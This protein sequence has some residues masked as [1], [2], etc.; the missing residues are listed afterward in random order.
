MF[1]V[2]LNIL[3]LRYSSLI[4][5]WNYLYNYSFDL[6]L[7]I[8]VN[9]FIKLLILEFTDPFYIFQVFSVILWMFNHYQIYESLIIVTTIISLIVSTFET[10]ANLLSIQRM[11]KYSCPINVYRRNDNGEREILKID[12]TELVPATYS[13][14]RTKERQCP[15]IA[16]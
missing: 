2:N 1:F 4:H 9:S 8:E 7:H 10:R 6:D 16:F 5:Q 15:V 14:C 3:L 11:A 13:K 12:S